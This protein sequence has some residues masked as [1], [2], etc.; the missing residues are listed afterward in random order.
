MRFSLTAGDGVTA[1]TAGE[2]VAP[3]QNLMANLFQ[4]LEFKIGGITVSQINSYVSQVNSL[5]QRM[6]YG[7]S[8]LDSVG[9]SLNYSQ[10]SLVDRLTSLTSTGLINLEV[11]W[12]PPL[13]IFQY[14]GAIPGSSPFEIILTPQ[15]SSQFQV[16]AVQTGIAVEPNRDFRFDVESCY[17]Y[18]NV[19]NGPR[20]DN[21]TYYIDLENIRCQVVELTTTSF[22]Q[23]SFEVT[24]GTHALSVAFQDGRLDR[25]TFSAAQFH[26]DEKAELSLIRFYV[27]AFGVQRPSP[28][29]DPSF[30]VGTDRTTQRY[31]ETLAETGLLHSCSDAES[32]KTWQENGVYFHQRFPKDGS[33]MDTRSS[34]YSVSRRCRYLQW[35]YFVVRP[36]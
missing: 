2:G 19:L 36:Q 13:S 22:S 20:I 35:T 24:Q 21:S 12:K 6:N 8:W 17:F 14:E 3:N 18:A 29:A 16:S 15:S 7:K 30:L 33:N 31:F 5:Q 25:S 1:L 9:L 11:I 27:D 34:A 10:S 28:D 4:S 23:R 32:K 26:L